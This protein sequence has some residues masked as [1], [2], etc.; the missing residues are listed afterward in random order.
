MKGNFPAVL[1]E[2]L[3]HEGGWADHPKDP[4]GATMKGITLVTYRRYRPGAT[5]AQLRDI[6]NDEV[7]AIYRD[8]YWTPIRGDDLPIGVDLSVFDYGVNSGPSRSVKDA[9]RV[10][11]ADDDGVLGDKTLFAI[12]A[13]PPRTFIKRHCARRLSFVKSLAI[14]ETFGRGWSRRIA[15]VEAA[16]LSWVSTKPELE[17]DAKEATGDAGKS[18]GGAVGTGAGGVAVDQAPDVAW[19]PWWAI[20]GLVVVVAVPFVIRAAIHLQ[21]AVA[22]RQAAREA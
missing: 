15:S 14:W 18:A 3:P 9:Q 8:G 6:P 16:G 21:R 7:E 22:L 11:G 19:L 1:A 10:S 4:G 17:Q 5:K 2:T 12:S 13:M 20:V